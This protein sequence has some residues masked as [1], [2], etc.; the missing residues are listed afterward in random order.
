MEKKILILGCGISG[1]TLARLFKEAGYY[2]EIR[3]KGDII[4]GMLSD[5]WNDDGKCYV[6][7]NGAHIIHFSKETEDAE[8]FLK[9]HTKLSPFR[10]KVLCLGNNSSFT[11]WP[12]NLTYKELYEYMFPGKSVVDEFVI[13]Y[14]KKMWKNHLKVQMENFKDRPRFKEKNNQNQDFFEGERQYQPMEGYTNMIKD[15]IKDCKLSYNKP[16]DLNSL[17]KE[18][19][20]LD[21]IIVTSHIDSFF[22]YKFGKLQFRGLD[23]EFKTIESDENILPASVVNLNRHPKYIRVAELNQLQAKPNTSKKKILCFDFPSDK[24]RFYPV[25]T[26]KNYAKLKKYYEYALKFGNI[27]FCGRTADYKYKD[28]DDSIMDAMKLFNEL[29]N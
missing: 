1:A 5:S 20:N 15:L 17:K 6:S 13:P 24:N 22:G 12:I 8:Q 21:Y 26:E 10:H 14:S 4:G 25:E 3:E 23:F 29:K 7:W 19:K 9:K 18:I 28:I 2:V 11:Y 27:K 16:E